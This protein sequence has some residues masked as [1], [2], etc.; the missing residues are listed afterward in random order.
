MR[1]IILSLVLGLLAAPGAAA[2]YY[3]DAAGGSDSNP[4]RSEAAAWKTVGKINS[5]SFSPG[6]SVLFRRGGEWL[7]EQLVVPSSGSPS[8]PLT[9]GAYGTGA[10]PL[11]HSRRPRTKHIGTVNIISRHDVVVR[12]LAIGVMPGDGS[13]RGVHIERGSN[14]SVIDCA[15]TGSADANTRGVMVYQTPGFVIKGCEISHTLYGIHL[16]MTKGGFAGLIEANRIHDLDKGDA[17]DW[18]G[19]KVQGP[20]GTDARGLVIRGNEIWKFNEDGID[21]IYVRNVV[22]EQNHIHD[23]AAAKISENQSG[24]KSREEGSVIRDNRIENIL[25]PGEHRQGIIAYGNRAKVTGNTIE[26]VGDR[27]ILLEGNLDAEVLDNVISGARVGIGVLSGT[28]AKI[29]RNRICARSAGIEI[30][31]S[32]IEGGGNVFAGA[33]IVL[34]ENAGYN[35][36]DPSPSPS[37]TPCPERKP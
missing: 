21:M 6:D 24:I 11:L 10:P 14:V 9:F 26:G 32:K 34:R 30:D 31:G 15:I 37:P 29:Q 18:D 23:S 22:V 19:I 36:D 2:T 28:K 4:G 7:A 27:A 3:V 16:D 35:G 25:S 20:K 5:A 1:T 8:K 13:A 33:R 12:D 17:K